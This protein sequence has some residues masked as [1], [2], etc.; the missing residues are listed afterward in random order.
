MRL[1]SLKLHSFR[2]YTESIISF[3]KEVNVISGEN[4]QGKTNLL[5]AIYYLGLTQSFRASM[6]Q[7]CLNHQDKSPYFDISGT[8]INQ[9]ELEQDVRVYFSK[10]EKKHLFVD[11][12]RE[13]KFKDHV[14]MLP[15]VLLK[16]DDLKL[17]YG[18]PGIRRKFVDILLSQLSPVYM[19]DLM[20]YS[21]ALK[22]K[23]ALLVSDS[24]DKETLRLWNT[25]LLEYGKRVIRKRYEILNELEHYVQEYY[26]MIS[27]KNEQT[28]VKYMS[29][30][31]NVETIEDEFK[32]KL[33]QNEEKE[34][35]YKRALI[36]PHRDDIGFFINK[37]SVGSF[38]SQGEN[39][40]FLISLKL[41]EI[42]LFSVYVEEKPMLLFD[43]IFSELDN[44]RVERLLAQLK[45]F[46]QTFITT[47]DKNLVKETPVHHIEIENGACV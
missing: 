18:S 20:R 38:G 29:F 14:G 32:Q 36:G 10:K 42:Q 22:H 28:R 6:D 41:A 31:S 25:Q 19:N 15:M 11:G 26:P 30:F 24:T 27:G 43:D 9:H 44:T 40:T 45:H 39:K 7:E 35:R 46:G 37:K 1:K 3:D 21:R 12:Q 5:E 4:G 13:R 34:V 33:E 17:T 16:P 8:F 47:T 2:N 23:N